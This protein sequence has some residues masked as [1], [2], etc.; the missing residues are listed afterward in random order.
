M[1]NIPRDGVAYPSN[2]LQCLIW[3]FFRLFSCSYPCCTHCLLTF[4]QFW[5][6]FRCVFFPSPS[7]IYTHRQDPSKTPLL[8]D[9]EPQLSQS[10]LV[11]QMLQ[12]HSLWCFYWT[13]LNRPMC[14]LYWEPQKW[15]PV[16]HPSVGQKRSTTMF[17]MILLVISISFLRILILINFSF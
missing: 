11:C 15:I 10:L 7:G 3:V 5:E 6:E 9:E 13:L 1:L 2:L 8:Q 4:F 14:L 12:L 17:S 16:V